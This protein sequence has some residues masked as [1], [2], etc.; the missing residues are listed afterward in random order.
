M[1]LNGI[2]TTINVAKQIIVIYWKHN[3]STHST[4]L[5]DKWEFQVLVLHEKKEREKKT[6]AAT[7]PTYPTRS[8]KLSRTQL[9][10]PPEPD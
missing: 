10:R 3:C 6:F 7:W 9:F 1:S 2:A 4:T 5:F 8:R